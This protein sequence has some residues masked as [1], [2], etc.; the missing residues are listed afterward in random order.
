MSYGTEKTWSPA[1]GKYQYLNK[2]WK[3]VH[4]ICFVDPK[5]QLSGG[6]QHMGHAG[7][8][9]GG[10]GI[11]VD[12]TLKVLIT[13]L[14]VTSRPDLMALY[15]RQRSAGPKSKR[16]LAAAAALAGSIG[17]KDEDGRSSKAS[18]SLEDDDG[19]GTTGSL[20]GGDSIGSSRAK[21]SVSSEA[22]EEEPAADP[23]QMALPTMLMA[24]TIWGSIFRADLSKN[25]VDVETNNLCKTSFMVIISG[26]FWAL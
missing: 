2:V 25:K 17:S 7:G 16:A 4:R 14:S 13:A 10:G 6:I 18:G 21:G 3:P 9:G 24:G 22:E 26:F 8:A 5:P 19:L 12:P 1:L 11:A 23:T 20:T 15:A